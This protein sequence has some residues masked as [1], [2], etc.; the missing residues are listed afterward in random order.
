MSPQGRAHIIGEL[1][2]RIRNLRRV[3]VFKKWKARQEER[4]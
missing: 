1:D 2:R 3:F 4:A